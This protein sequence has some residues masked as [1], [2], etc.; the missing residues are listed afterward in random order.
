M[1]LGLWLA[2]VLCRG[3]VQGADEWRCKGQ[4]QWW[5]C[6]AGSRRRGRLPPPPPVT[7]PPCRLPLPL[8]FKK[9]KK[10]A[11]AQEE[12]EAMYLA[13]ANSALCIALA[14]MHMTLAVE[15]VGGACLGC[16]S[17]GHVV[18]VLLLLELNAGASMQAICCGRALHA[19]QQ[20]RLHA[21]AAATHHRSRHPFFSRR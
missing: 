9:G 16:S 21:T 13:G 20:R 15:Q 7:L 8:Q 4:Q 5:Q 3:A 6:Q 11:K 18:A 12:A 2:L 10:R 17:G 1:R 14:K 19:Q